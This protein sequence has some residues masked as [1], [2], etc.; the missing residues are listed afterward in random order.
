MAPFVFAHS[1]DKDKINMAAMV[2]KSGQYEDD[3]DPMK[4]L[5]SMVASMDGIGNKNTSSQASRHALSMV[6]FDCLDRVLT[7]RNPKASPRPDPAILER[8]VELKAHPGLLTQ[9]ICTSKRPRKRATAQP[10]LNGKGRRTATVN[11]AN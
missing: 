7:G 10:V 1:I 11:D 6:T 2:Y 8:F 3:N 5:R 9:R 4:K